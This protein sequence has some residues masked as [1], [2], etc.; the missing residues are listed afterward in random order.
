MAFVH[1]SRMAF[2]PREPGAIRSSDGRLPSPPASTTNRR[3]DQS[4]GNS[5]TRGTRTRQDD[6][7]PV[8][9]PA[10]V[11]RPAH[12][13]A[14]PSY[15]DYSR[16]RQ[17]STPP[18]VTTPGISRFQRSPP[19]LSRGSRAR[20]PDVAPENSLPWRQQENMY[21]RDGRFDGG[22]DYFER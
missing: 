16:S 6:Y 20:S 18:A 14:S 12:G 3:P 22:G 9:S 15:D 4:A 2:V 5:G 10:P 17:D 7:S 13:R 11:S 21:R 8:R 1:P 19:P